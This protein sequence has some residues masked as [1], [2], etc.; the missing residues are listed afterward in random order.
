MEWLKEWIRNVAFYYLFMTVVLNILPEGKEKKY[1]QFYLGLL[2][3]LFLLRPVLHLGKLETIVERNVIG[4]ITEE[5]FQQIQR[6]IRQ[7][8]VIS[9]Q[10][11]VQTYEEEM[12]NQVIQWLATYGYETI[13]CDVNLSLSDT[14]EL[15]HIQIRVKN[16]QEH[17]LSKKEQEDFL[18]KE[19][20]EVYNIPP[21]NINISIQG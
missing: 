5:Y 16:Q 1:V 10:Y 3:T 15:E 21:G 9:D 2:A 14:M 19:F 6:E 20:M 11:L 8:D 13:S 17:N 4:T 12:K 7:I 18:K